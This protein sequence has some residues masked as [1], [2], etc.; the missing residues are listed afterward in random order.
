M[1]EVAINYL[2]VLAATISSIIIGFLWY[3]PLFGKTWMRLMNFN[4]KKIKE[5]KNKGMTKSYFF[6]SL[7]SLVTSY[8]LAHFVDYV[9]ATTISAGLQLSFWLWVGFFATTMLSSIL[10][11]ER[12]VKLYLI[13]VLHYLVSF[14][15]MT[16]ILVLWV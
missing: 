16:T 8:V 6:M 11:E 14:A 5:S 2:A 3:G 10:W 1:V 12:P 9:G 15:V 4:K 13:N 7:S